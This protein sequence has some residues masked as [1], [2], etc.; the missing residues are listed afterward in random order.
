MSSRA[1]RAGIIWAGVGMLVAG[2]HLRD[3]G[4]GNF[5]WMTSPW[6]SAAPSPVAARA[7][8]P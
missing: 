7:A 1:R 2:D 3:A 4:D 6:S 5:V 8:S